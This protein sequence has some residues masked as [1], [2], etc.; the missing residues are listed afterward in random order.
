MGESSRRT[1]PVSRYSGCAV[2]ASKSR[3]N[4]GQMYSASPAI[5]VSA[6]AAYCS[7]QSDA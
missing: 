7:G 6:C 5:T 1:T 4:A 2:P 3:Q